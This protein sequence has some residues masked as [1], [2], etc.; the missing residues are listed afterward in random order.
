MHHDVL[1]IGAGP[2]GS[3]AAYALAQAGRSVLI[4]DKQPFPRDKPCGGGL[5]PK[6][7]KRLPFDIS[8]LIESHCHQVELTNNGKHPHHLPQAGLFCAMVQRPGFD[9]F[10]LQQ[11]LQPNSGTAEQRNPSNR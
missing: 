5:T 8:H 11:A 1:I 4:L 10:L 7:L 9:Q 2:A 6:T 3:S